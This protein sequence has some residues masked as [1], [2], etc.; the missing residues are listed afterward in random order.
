M[1]VTTSSLSLISDTLLDCR[2]T[3]LRCDEANVPPIEV[4]GLEG[5]TELCD[6]P[7]G[8][9]PEREGGRANDPVSPTL[10]ARLLGR[11][12]SLVAVDIDAMDVLA[13]SKG[14]GR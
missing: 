9:L 6:W 3:R 10:L 13:L 11:L 7:Y 12:D 8:A 1:G 2:C 4:R 5:R 14:C